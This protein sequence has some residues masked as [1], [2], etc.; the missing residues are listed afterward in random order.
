MFTHQDAIDFYNGDGTDPQGNTAA[1]YMAFTTQDW[2]ERHDIIQWAFPTHVMSKFNPDAPLIDVSTLQLL[3]NDQLIRLRST[4]RHILLSYLHS[5][6]IGRLLKPEFV[7]LEGGYDVSQT[8]HQHLRITRVIT[9][10]RLFGQDEIAA[11]F[12]RFMLL[13]A[14][15]FPHR[16]NNLTVEF[17]NKALTEKL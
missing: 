8:S 7:L 3:S 11:N 2:D 12:G 16:I 13:L 10:L 9:S 6:G 1:D 15:Q 17:W 4:Q 5:I 14:E